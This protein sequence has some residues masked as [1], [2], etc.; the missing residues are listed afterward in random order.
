MRANAKRFQADPNRFI[1]IGESAG[2][3]M[4]SMLGVTNGLEPIRQRC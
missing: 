4:A 2:G 1:A 3:H